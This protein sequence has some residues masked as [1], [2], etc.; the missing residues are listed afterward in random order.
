MINMLNA[1]LLLLL[2]Y[3]KTRLKKEHYLIRQDNTIYKCSTKLSF[4]SI[5]K[6]DNT[7][8][9]NRKVPYLYN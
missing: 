9:T 1:Q 6:S 8:E 3:I 4:S 7:S 5:D 2:L